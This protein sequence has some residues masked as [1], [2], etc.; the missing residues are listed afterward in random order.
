MR[1]STANFYETGVARLMEKQTS[2]AKIQQ[3]IA[4]GRRILAPS[5]DPVGSARALEISQSQS[6]N[7]QYGVNRQ[8][9]KDALNLVESNLGSVT[10]LLQDAKTA[11]IQAGNGAFSDAD[12]N[13][14]AIDL[15]EQLDQLVSLA[16]ARD[17]LGNYMYSGYKSDTQPF[18]R[19]AAGATYIG[20]SGQQMVQVDGS[21]QIAMNVTGDTVFGTGTPQDVFKT[22]NDLVTLLQTPGTAGLTAGLDTAHGNIDKALDNVLT[23]RASVG[24]RLKE[25]ESLDNLGTDVDLQYSD[26][27]STIQD[28]DY[29]KAASDLT[30]QKI[31]LDAA[32]QTFVQI[33][34]LSLF[35]Y[36]G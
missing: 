22:L 13:S 27:L 23:V 17:G 11:V 34:K 10:T 3:Q 2:L 7:T 20:D 29:A 26:A 36:I 25:I 21:R 18:T 6:V 31:T 4:T 32:Q 33:S 5:D 28:L 35:N 9:V 16:N 30:Q 24:A 8:N 15:K 12:R 19:T 14:I 1:I